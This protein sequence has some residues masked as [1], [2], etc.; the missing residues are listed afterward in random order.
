MIGRHV[1]SGRGSLPCSGTYLFLWGKTSSLFP[2]PGKRSLFS[3][4]RGRSVALVRGAGRYGWNPHAAAPRGGVTSYGSR[5]RKTAGIS[6]S[7]DRP[8][9]GHTGV[10]PPRPPKG[11]AEGRQLRSECRSGMPCCGRKSNASPVLRCPRQQGCHGPASGGTMDRAPVPC[12]PAVLRMARDGKG[13][14][15]AM[16]GG[17]DKGLRSR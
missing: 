14:A 5:V 3:E 13:A 17:P 16:G 11:R 6:L 15:R 4:F 7:Y 1:P 2:R 8:F 9:D 10:H 12:R